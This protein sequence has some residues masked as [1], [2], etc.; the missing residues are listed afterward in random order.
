MRN[1][2]MI[3]PAALLLAS[4]TFVGAQDKTQQQAPAPS[5]G[6]VSIGGRF[7][8]SSGDKARYERYQDLRSGVPVSVLFNKETSNWT[9]DLKATNIGYRDQGYVANFNS[10][11]VKFSVLFD[12]T[13]TN[14]MYDARSPYNC[15]AGNCALDAALRGQIQ[16]ARGT[17]LNAAGA[18]TPV[19]TTPIGVPQNLAQLTQAGTIYNSV[20]KSFD[21]QSLRSTFAANLVYAAT[22]NLNLMLGYD[23]YKKSGQQPW[24]TSF[25]FPNAVEV[26]LV[27]DNKTTDVTAAMEWASHQGMMRMGYAY[28]KFDQGIPSFTFDNPLYATDYN[29]F[30]PAIGRVLRPERLQ[31]V[32]GRRGLRPDGRWRR[33]TR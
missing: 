30:S 2:L 20:A 4:A 27:I 8:S 15:T 18:Y 29:V 32:G 25:A 33:P 24:G 22:D 28:S 13:P 5:S 31:L 12:Q 1:R 26:P 21:M 19:N 16:A 7:T 3:G 23:M 17:K 6:E 14:Y 10:R 11:R 9:F